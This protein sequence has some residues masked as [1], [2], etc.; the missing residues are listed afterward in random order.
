M[1]KIIQKKKGKKGLSLLSSMVGVLIMLSAVSGL[2]YLS[3]KMMETSTGEAKSK[4]ITDNLL[5]NFKNEVRVSEYKKLSDIYNG[6]KTENYLDSG[7]DIETKVNKFGPCDK[8][9]VC[10]FSIVYAE[11][12]KDGKVVAVQPISRVYTHFFKAEP[13]LYTGNVVQVPLDKWKDINS[14]SYEAWGAGGGNGGTD[15]GGGTGGM[16][17]AGGYVKGKLIKDNNNI[18]IMVG[19]K[20]GTGYYGNS[21]PGASAGE[22]GAGGAG[23]TAGHIQRSGAGGAGGGR[24]AIYINGKEIVTAG[25]G[26][27]GGGGSNAVVGMVGSLN[28]NFLENIFE[29]GNGATCPT[30][31]GGG[32]GGGGGHFGGKG[33]LNGFDYNFLDLIEKK[34][35]GRYK[36]GRHGEGGS[37]GGSYNVTFDKNNDGYM[38]VGFDA[39]TRCISNE[40]GSEKVCNP[41]GTSPGGED[42]PTRGNAGSPNEDGKINIYYEREIWNTL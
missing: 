3:T 1:L 42:V 24:S 27:G 29:G 21:A 9:G 18:S 39:I 8:D 38:D 23:G 32:G 25:G 5:E 22:Y 37:F 7:Y 4:D 31:G 30:D 10:D 34:L 16:G 15:T 6:K 20:G 19:Q 41:Y 33:G 17:G 35:T 12:K 14:I 36:Y 40:D 28:N 11:L 2:S 13:F 26:G